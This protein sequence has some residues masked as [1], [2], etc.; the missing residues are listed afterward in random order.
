MKVPNPRQTADSGT[1]LLELMAVISLIVIL[2]G[3]T[4]P[5]VASFL[6]ARGMT[7]AVSDIVSLVE[8]ARNEAMTTQSLVWLCFEQGV[9]TQGDDELRAVILAPVDST[10]FTITQSG[11]I[12]IAA[13]SP[14][15]A[16]YR[17]PRL[18]LVALS[19]LPGVSEL[20][21]PQTDSSALSAQ[22]AQPF[23]SGKTTTSLINYQTITFTPQGY[24]MLKAIPLLTDPYAKMIDLGLQQT[25]AGGQASD[26]DNAGLLLN[27]FN[28]QIR[29]LRR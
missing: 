28:G 6:G 21:A 23:R 13:T 9:D 10:P 20:A 22:K 7:R 26:I 18:K 3:L 12:T 2:I 11:K 19:A 16:V 24:A 29:V 25:R 4:A 8:T 17:W 27:G 15:T 14:E 5:A 1:S